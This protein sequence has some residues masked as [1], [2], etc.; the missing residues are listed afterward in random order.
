MDFY[1]TQ[2]RMDGAICT[3]TKSEQQEYLKK[4]KEN[5][6]VNIEMEATAFG[7]LCKEV[8]IPCAIVCVSLVD[9]MLGD[10]VHLTSEEMSDIEKRLLRLIINVIK[11]KIQA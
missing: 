7:M 8:G 1:E 11:R 4:L 9:R 6:V 3:F 10:Q 5:G 2:A